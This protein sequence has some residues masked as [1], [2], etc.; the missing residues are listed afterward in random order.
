MNILNISDYSPGSALNLG[1][2]KSTYPFILVLSS[3][4]ELL[5]FDQ[6]LMT[7]IDDYAGIFG[8]QIPF[9]YGKRIKKLYLVA[10]SRSRC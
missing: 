4:C 3:H 1:I 7:R 9:Y 6:Q 5:T 2:A 10:L 8:L